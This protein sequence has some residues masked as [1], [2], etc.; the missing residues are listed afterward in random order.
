MRSLQVSFC[1]LAAAAILSGQAMTVLRVAADGNKVV[2]T[3]EIVRV[4]GLKPGSEVTKQE[5]VA[6]AER[7]MA[8]GKFERVDY[9]WQPQPTGIIVTFAVVEKL[10]EPEIPAAQADKPRIRKVVFEGATLVP[11][12]KLESALA[13]VA[14]DRPYDEKEFRETLDNLLRP[15][16][17]E[18]GHW[19]PRFTPKAEPTEGGVRVVVTVDE[20]EPV[21]LSAVKIEGGDEKWIQAAG[22]PVGQVATS[23]TVHAA[24]GRVRQAMERDGYLK[25][26]LVA[27]EE[28]EGDQLRLV[29]KAEKGSKFVFRILVLEGL[30]RDAEARAR[31]LWKL[32]SGDTMNPEFV[33]SFVKEVYAARLAMATSVE[34][35][36][37]FASGTTDAEVVLRFR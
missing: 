5:I 3:E 26:S 29:L 9:R 36:I 13:G 18:R 11:A 23:K 25:G 24:M 4:S 6:A 28:L 34:R 1:L 2:K 19:D 10:L 16:Y 20:G 12:T 30:G 32:K 17:S 8:T 37:R 33:E 21:K 27:R 31:K 35:E 22:F 7:V 15:L 14:E